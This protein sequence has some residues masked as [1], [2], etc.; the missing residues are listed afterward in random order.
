MTGLCLS[1]PPRS[2][3]STASRFASKADG[4]DRHLQ[5][6]WLEDRLVP[7]ITFQFDYSYDTLGF[8]TDSNRRA[9]LERAG[10]DL[11]SRIQTPLQ[12]IVPGG[13]N[14]WTARFFHPATGN[15]IT[16]NNLRV[17]QDTLLVFV[18][19]Q[20]MS[21]SEVGFGGPGGY[22]VAGSSSWL[23]T[24]ATRGRSGFSTWGG[25]VTFSHHHHWYFGTEPSELNSNTLDFYSVAIHELGHVLGFGTSSE[26][27]GYLNN[28]VF[29]GPTATAVYGSAPPIEPDQVHWQ[30]GIHSGGQAV[31]MQPH[32]QRNQRVGFSELDYAALRDIG[33]VISGLPQVEV[34]RYPEFS[35]PPRLP[36]NTSITSVGLGGIPGSS[37]RSIVSVSGTTSGTVQVFSS[38]DGRL[39]PI[40]PELRPFGDFGGSVRSATADINDDGVPDL[41][42][43][44]GPGGGSKIRILDGKTFQDL[45][46]SFSAFE[47]SFLGG[48]FLATGDFTGDGRPEIVISPD[49]GGGGRV[50][51]LDVS[52]GNVRVVADFMGIDDVHFRGGARVGVGDI[53][54]D[55]IAELIVAA[56]FGGGPRVA[57]FDGRF[58][59]SGQPTRL[60]PDF[61]A[62]E[63]T[64]RNGVYVSVGDVNGDGFGDLIFGAGPGGGPRVLVVSGV[65]LLLN[66]VAAVAA[67]L[68][69]FFAG[70]EDERGGVR[71]ASKDLDGNGLADLIT[72]SGENRSPGQLR[73]FLGSPATMLLPA[74]SVDPFGP[75]TLDGIFVG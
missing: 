49:Q 60:V 31:S 9:V 34:S 41:I 23:N 38:L 39:Q 50:R 67:P 16:V 1:F 53:N 42:V 48:V 62:Y 17:P 6:E 45:I 29:T 32:L 19:S 61:F 7:A 4:F 44:T 37:G 35:L 10:A 33:W 66:P 14:S 15:Q 65:D 21:G 25:S 57:I 56:G 72:G 51:I 43:G 40:S 3:C 64:L 58:V 18:G 46:P 73:V 36:W 74:A 47:E 63:P 69:D 28:G 11:A 20:V 13:G 75:V 30:Q 59:A 22:Q 2:L 12:A 5:C 55:G 27:A 54:G 8:F 52:T 71:V 24:V 68:Y 26:F 70:P